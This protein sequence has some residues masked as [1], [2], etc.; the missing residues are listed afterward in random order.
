[1]TTITREQMQRL[2]ILSLIEG[3]ISVYM[4]FEEVEAIQAAIETIRFYESSNAAI[5]TIESRKEGRPEQD[6]A[7]FLSYSGLSDAPLLRY[8]YFHG[9]GESMDKPDIEIPTESD[10]GE[11]VEI[12]CSSHH[13]VNNEVTF[14]VNGLISYSKALLG[15]YGNA[16]DTI[17]E[18]KDDIASLRQQLEDYKEVLADKRSLTREIDVIMNGEDGAARQPSLCDVVAQLRREWPAL[19]DQLAASQKESIVELSNKARALLRS[20][21]IDAAIAKGDV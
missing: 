2:N 6:Y 8:A 5:D 11:L 4:L 15:K 19:R 20:D 7:H 12:Y 10:I 9:A 1:M 21:N 16:A 13:V 14:K 18:Q 17:D 3:D